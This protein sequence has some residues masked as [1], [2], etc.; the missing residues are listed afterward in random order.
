MANVVEK[1][2][3]SFTHGLITN[4]GP[5]ADGLLSSAATAQERIANLCNIDR[6]FAQHKPNN[7][8]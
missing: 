1:I 5:F 2:K 3:E 8:V 7:K 6:M 4:A